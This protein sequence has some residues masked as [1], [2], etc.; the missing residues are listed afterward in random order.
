[1]KPVNV[2][3]IVRSF[4]KDN[5]EY[6][7]LVKST[8]RNLATYFNQDKLVSLFISI[9]DE[10]S[11]ISFNKPQDRRITN[12]NLPSYKVKIDYELMPNSVR[13]VVNRNGTG[14]DIKSSI[15]H[16]GLITPFV[17]KMYEIIKNKDK[18][19]MKE[20]LPNDE[21]AKDIVDILT[22]LFVINTTDDAN[23]PVFVRP[24]I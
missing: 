22:T 20:D 16:E 19:Y 18:E 9:I 8:R 6:M 13:T 5:K 23:S 1:M 11:F 3:D 21:E 14:S 12:R 4:T 15:I 24:F 17:T 2:H 7:D 10:C